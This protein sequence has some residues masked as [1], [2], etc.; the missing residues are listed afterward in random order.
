MASDIPADAWYAKLVDTAVLLGLMQGYPDGTF[1]PDQC[2]SRAELAAVA[3][4]QAL[5][6]LAV[7][8]WESQQLRKQVAPAVVYIQAGNAV[9]AGVVI[10]PS[11]IIATCHHVIADLQPNQPLYCT[12]TDW[13][14]GAH[15]EPGCT[16]IQQAPELDLALLQ[17][18]WPSQTFPWIRLATTPAEPAEPVVILGSPEAFAGWES[19]GL[20]ARSDVVLQTY[21]APEDLICVSGA[22]NPGNSGGALVRASDGTLLGIVDAKLVD[23]TVENMGFA[24]PASSVAVLLAKAGVTQP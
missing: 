9:G 18:V 15:A 7:Q 8:R 21:Q 13:P 22:V 2:V 4:R 16:V 1:R 20:I 17:I 5:N 11:G 24:V 10:H 19:H 6:G 14:D 23:V 12:W 3:V